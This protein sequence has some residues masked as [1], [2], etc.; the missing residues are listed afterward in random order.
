MLY[1]CLE[2]K[3]RVPE[4]PLSSSSSSQEGLAGLGFFGG[5]TCPSLGYFPAELECCLSS[6]S[7]DADAK[8]AEVIPP[9]LCLCLP[10]CNYRLGLFWSVDIICCASL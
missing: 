10:C 2:N 7:P 9:G 1:N 4:R 6:S 3:G 5:C 8:R